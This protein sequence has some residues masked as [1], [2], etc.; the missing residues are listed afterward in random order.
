MLG[1][2][3]TSAQWGR[4]LNVTRGEVRRSQRNEGNRLRLLLTSGLDDERLGKEAAAARAVDI[5]DGWNGRRVVAAD[6]ASPHA[7]TARGQ[8]TPAANAAQANRIDAGPVRRSS[9]SA[10]GAV[11]QVLG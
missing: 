7:A 1:R 10:R 2:Q 6:M 9:E 5:D 3:P 4:T 8:V 11:T